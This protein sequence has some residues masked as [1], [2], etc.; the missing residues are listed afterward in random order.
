VRVCFLTH[1]YPPEVGAPQTRIELLARTLAARGE[2]VTV[3]TGFPHYPDGAIPAPYRNRPFAR[4]RAGGVTVVRS[5][6]Y[7]TANRGFARRLADHTAFAASCL[8]TASLSG[9]TDVVVA[10]TPPLFCAAAAV[11][12]AARKRAALIVNVADLWP[13]SAVA[14]GALRDPRAIA[15]A[16]ALEHWIYRHADLITTPTAGIAERLEALPSATG[17]ARRVWPVVDVGRFSATP[18]RGAPSGSAPLRLLYAGTIGL[19]QG[20]DTLVEASRLAGPEV[21]ATT[22]AGDGALAGEL[23]ALVAE[24]RVENVALLGAVAPAQV[25]GLY[26]A[27]DAAAVLLRDLPLLRGALPTKLLE[28]LAAGRPVVLAAHG[29]AA[30]LVR[31]AGAGLVVAPGDPLA[32]AG[33]LTCLHGDPALRRSLGD[34]G[35]RF[36]RERFGVEPAVVEWSRALADVASLHAART[37]QKRSHTS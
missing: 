1:Y 23:R 16:T 4:E 37:S 21:V 15:A 18:E 20:L 12:Y 9:P 3:H 7:P 33:A 8:L 30:A 5:A 26:A 24:R 10:E 28:A 31:E 11:A 32:L 6:V 25:P 14:L 36:A 13:E 22:I 27:A 19:A 2:Q 34:A 35:Q 29:E 17:R